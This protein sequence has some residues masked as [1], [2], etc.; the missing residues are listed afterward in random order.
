MKKNAQIK[1]VY[2][3]GEFDISKKKKLIYFVK[4]GVSK[5]FLIVLKNCQRNFIKTI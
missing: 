1:A 2:D 3:I 5:T 4:V